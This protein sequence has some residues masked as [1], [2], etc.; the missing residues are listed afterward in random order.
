MFGALAFCEAKV[1]KKDELV[2]AATDHAR[3]LRAE[4]GCLAAYV[5]AERGT[6]GQVSLSVFETEEAFRRA[7]QA[8]LPVIQGHH[9]ERLLAKPPEF[10]YFDVR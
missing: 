9:L 2:A 4:P 3:A 8:T 1:G 10:R 6:Q 7:A 5:L